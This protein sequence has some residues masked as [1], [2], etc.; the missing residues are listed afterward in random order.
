[1]GTKD[2]PRTSR[3]RPG[4]GQPSEARVPPSPDGTPDEAVERLDKAGVKVEKVDFPALTLR[5]S[6]A[7]GPMLDGEGLS[8][9]PW[10]SRT[11]LPTFLGLVPILREP[12]LG[13][14]RGP[15]R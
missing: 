14:L 1:V 3:R 10:W 6:G 11:D 8:E 2:V 9:G 13:C 4:R 12:V 7:L 5:V 15:G